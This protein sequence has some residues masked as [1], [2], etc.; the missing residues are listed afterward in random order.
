MY[1][2]WKIEILMNEIEMD[3]MK[4]NKNLRVDQ[5]KKIE[6]ELID[7]IDKICRK[8]G[9]KYSLMGGTGIGA[10]RHHGFI[11]WDDDIDIMMLR[12]EYIRF[13]EIMKEN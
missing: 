1:Y 9:I 8:N 4:M 12:E 5:I 3:R 7:K 2:R 6:L 11:P 10:I 13:E